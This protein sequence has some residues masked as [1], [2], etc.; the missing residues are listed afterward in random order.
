DVVQEL[1]QLEGARPH[2]LD[3]RRLLD[4]VEIVANVVDAAAGGAHDVVESREVADEEGFGGRAVGVEAA[5]GHGLSAAGLVTRVDDLVSEA[6]EQL[7][8]R[9]ADL[10]IEG[11]DEAGDE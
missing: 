3:R 8:R 9:D 1:D 11:I 5:V 6:L 2:L 7:E 4:R 10:G